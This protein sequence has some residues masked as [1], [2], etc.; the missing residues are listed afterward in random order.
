MLCNPWIPANRKPQDKQALFL[1]HTHVREILFGGAAFG[2]KSVA[3]LSAALQYVDTPGY[4]ALI[5]RR[6]FRQLSQPK[7]L[8]SLSHEWLGGSAARWNGEKNQWVFPSGATLTFGHM[9]HPNAKYD[10]QGAAYHFVGYDELTQFDEDMYTYLFSRRRRAR[11]HEWVKKRFIPDDYLA[12][13]ERTK[14]SRTWWKNGRLFIPAKVEDNPAGDREE[15]EL[16]LAEL[17]ALER[18]QLQHGDWKAHAAGR[19]SRYWFKR[20]TDIG[21]AIRLSDNGTAIRKAE[22]NWIA[23]VDLA[24]STKKKS[25]YTV[26]L[27]IATDALGRQYVTDVVRVQIPPE[28]VAPLLDT[29]CQRHEPW[30]YLF[31]GI[32]ANGF[33]VAIVTEARRRDRYPHIPDVKELEPEGKSKLTRAT[34]AIIKAEAG[35][36]YVPEEAPWLDDFFGELEQFTGD[37]REDAYTDQVDTLAYGVQCCNR[38]ALDGGATEIESFSPPGFR[39]GR[40]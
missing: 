37:D 40:L 11:G 34:P 20:F 6:T 8:I 21:D 26:V 17:P 25:K 24:V 18:A 2:G 33:Q 19:F 9:D 14:F 32:E 22:L 1:W 39:G 13:D 27:S 30:R 35:R 3:M 36:I 29:L 31:V 12:A 23:T 15:F 28:K 16:S 4:D 7:A 5:L 38:Y 10:Y